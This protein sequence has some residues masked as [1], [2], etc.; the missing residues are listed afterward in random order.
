MNLSADSWQAQSTSSDGVTNAVT[1]TR[2]Q[3]TGL[4]DALRSRAV[5][6]APNA[7]VNTT[8]TVFSP[9]TKTLTTTSWMDDAS[10]T[11]R[12]TKFGVLILES[13]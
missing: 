11:I 10:P 4:S 3:M 12:K 9:A 7:S 5:R 6:I 2:Q 1:T 13:A 8:E